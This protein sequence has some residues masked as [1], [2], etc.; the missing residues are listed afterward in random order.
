MTEIAK[1]FHYKANF[2]FL[3][4]IFTFFHIYFKDLFKFIKSLITYE[5][6]ETVIF[7]INSESTFFLAIKYEKYAIN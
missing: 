1:K 4:K 3:W 7:L 6:F 5:P 2:N